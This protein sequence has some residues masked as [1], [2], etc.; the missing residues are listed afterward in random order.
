MALIDNITAY[1]KMDEA[2]GTRQDATASNIDLTDNNTVLAATGRINDGADFE[3]ANDE[4]LSVA[5]GGGVDPSGAFTFSFWIKYEEVPGSGVDDGWVGKWNSTGNQRSV[6][7]GGY[8]NAGTQQAYFLVTGNG[9]SNIGAFTNSGISAGNWYHIVAIYSPSTYVDLYVNNSRI[10]N[11]T[12]SVPA[13]IFNGTAEFRVGDF[14][15]ASVPF[16]GVIDEVGYWSRAITSTEVG[17]LY[18]SGSGL[19]Y[20]FG[21]ASGPANLKSYNT[22][23]KAN[24]KSINTNPIANIKSLNTNV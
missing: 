12:A 23:L 24:I 20:P 21:S 5:D 7:I 8:N 19:A 9:S 4:Y 18:N 2:S 14:V 15:S 1:W 13:S 22:N 10:Q 6:A 17:E 16:D 11:T 3:E